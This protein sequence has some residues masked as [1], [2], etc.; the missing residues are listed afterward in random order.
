LINKSKS[1]KWSTTDVRKE[2][3]IMNFPV[4]NSREEIF[5]FLNLSLSKID[6]I[7]YMSLTTEKGAYLSSWNNVWMKK[8]DQINMKAGLSMKNDKKSY[9]EL[10][11][12]VNEAKARVKAN[13]QRLYHILIGF[14]VVLITFILII[15]FSS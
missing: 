15:R 9:D 4:P 8:M 7:S 14:A 6:T 10:Q 13:T 12:L 5:E 11:V 1:A 2:E 3:L